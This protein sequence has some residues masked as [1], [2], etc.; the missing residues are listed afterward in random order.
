MFAFVHVSVGPG[1]VLVGRDSEEPP[2]VSSQTSI[3]VTP[4]PSQGTSGDSLDGRHV[5]K[6]MR[7]CDQPLL[8]IILRTHIFLVSEGLRRVWL[9][10]GHGEN[11]CQYISKALMK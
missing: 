9:G 7:V 6:A 5:E 1:G 11:L 2:G 3:L 4:P 8:D 10:F